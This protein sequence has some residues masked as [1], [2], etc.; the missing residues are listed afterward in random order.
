ML[1]QRSPSTVSW[2]H[3]DQELIDKV[4]ADSRI[5]PELIASLD[6]SRH[7]W[8]DD[9][10]TGVSGRPDEILVFHRL[11]ETIR[12]LAQSGHAILVGHGSTYMTRGLAAGTHVCLIAPMKF[13]LENLAARYSVSPREASRYLRRFERRRR[14]F[15]ARFSPS[16][17]A[18]EMFAAV[19]NVAELDQERLARA[20]MAMLPDTH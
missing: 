14:A 16:T 12:G 9:I 17:L 6:T 3:W 11:K 10:L 5:P 20:I 13:R 8:I 2:S 18:P 1:N 15:F 7:S 4:S 19:L